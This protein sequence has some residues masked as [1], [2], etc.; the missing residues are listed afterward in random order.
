MK[1]SHDQIL[2]K[3][4]SL[5]SISIS[6]MEVNSRQSNLKYLFY[7]YIGDS[8]KHNKVYL[9]IAKINEVHSLKNIKINIWNDV[10]SKYLVVLIIYL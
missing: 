6:I 1:D 10:I 2:W 9:I 5:A 7:N 3:N 8:N 4:Q